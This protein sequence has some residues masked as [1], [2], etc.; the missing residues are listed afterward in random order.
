MRSLLQSLAFS[1]LLAACLARAAEE[2]SKKAPV[3]DSLLFKNGDV[4]HGVLSAIEPEAGVQLNRPD[5]PQPLFF[6]PE[7]LSE[8][9]LSARPNAPTNAANQCVVR[10]INDDQL[11]GTLL[12]YDGE[13]LLLDTWYAGRLTLSNKWIAMILPQTAARQIVFEGPAGLEGWTMGNV[14]N[15][16]LTDTGQWMYRNGALYA[17]KSASIARD[18]KLP[19]MASLSFDMEWRGFFHVAIALYTEYLQPV[20][21]ANKETE[22]KFGGFYSLQIN[23][24]SANLLP[25]KQNDP[26]KYLGQ[27]TLQTS[28]AQKSSAHIDLRINKAKRIIALMIDGVLVKQWIDPDDFAGSGT[29]IRFVHQGQGAV[30]LTNIRV[31]DWDGQFEDVPILTPNKTQDISRLRNGDR[32]LGVVKSIEDGK[33]NVTGAG[34]PLQIP[35]SRVKQIELA[36]EKS[37]LAIPNKTVRAYFA[38][39]GTV[40]FVINKL[41]RESM[42]VLSPAFGSAKFSTSAFERLLFDLSLADAL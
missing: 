35:L 41:D 4:L 9:Q 1:L 17:V 42:S 6:T 8:I 19:D 40:S 11:Q 26:L 13:K 16:I 34:T 14:N 21:L 36:G 33:M 29:A 25:V 7:L 38:R 12:S 5:A 37:K 24:F 31:T 18:V 27:A 22:P 15:P 32:I 10:L 28:L 2:A 39:G 20:N 3:R 30:K 23:P